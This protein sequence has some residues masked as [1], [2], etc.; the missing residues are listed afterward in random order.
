MY[1]IWGVWRCTHSSPGVKA[2][3][4]QQG[5]SRVSTALG[6]YSQPSVPPQNLY[7]SSFLGPWELTGVLGR[8]DLAFISWDIELLKSSS[9]HSKNSNQTA[10]HQVLDISH[11]SGGD[12]HDAHL[13]MKRWH[14]SVN[15]NYQP[16][17]C[18]QK[19]LARFCIE[20][21]NLNV[22]LYFSREPTG[23]LMV[24][25]PFKNKRSAF[26][27]SDSRLQNLQP[28]RLRWWWKGWKLRF[29]Q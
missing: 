26:P 24:Q 18:E 27:L 8:P 15:L 23:V 9:S 25:K 19:S 22:F 7:S 13:A 14:A 3:A 16:M 5:A 28:G 1:A 4:C 29:Q 12:R 21:G 17:K 6:I 10:Q 2:V 11:L 20:R